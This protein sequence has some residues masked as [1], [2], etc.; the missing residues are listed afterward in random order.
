MLALQIVVVHEEHLQLLD[1]FPWEVPQFFHVGVHM[2][3]LCD[4]NESV[5]PDLLL[6]VDLFALDYSDQPR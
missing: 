6:A 2:V 5:V 4:S 3:G 1:P